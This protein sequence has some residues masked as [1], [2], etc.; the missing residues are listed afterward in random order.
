MNKGETNLSSIE[1]T[2]LKNMAIA[3]EK[4]E[5]EILQLN[6]ADHQNLC[7]K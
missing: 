2:Q 1:T 6:P 5:D 3:A 4:Y 7:R